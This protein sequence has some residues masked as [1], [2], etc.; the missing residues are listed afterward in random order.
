MA[1]RGFNDQDD[2]SPRSLLRG[3]ANYILERSR[4][5]GNNFDVQPEVDD[6]I[7]SQKDPSETEEEEEGTTMVVLLY[8]CMLDFQAL[9]SCK[10]AFCL[11]SNS[12]ASNLLIFSLF[13]YSGTPLS[14]TPLG[15]L[16]LS[17]KKRCPL[18]RGLQSTILSDLGPRQ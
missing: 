9:M 7:D 4:T 15:N 11:V 10:A 12:T 6:D 17:F 3:V 18:F 16:F 14:R 2:K 8:R 5:I 13:N 1:T